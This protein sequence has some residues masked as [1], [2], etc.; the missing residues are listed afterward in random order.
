MPLTY[1]QL[2]EP[3]LKSMIPITRSTNYTFELVCSWLKIIDKGVPCGV[4][5]ELW[6]SN[7]RVSGSIH[8]ASN[9]KKLFIHGLTQNS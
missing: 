1:F 7:P 5:V 6:P 9:L 8:G 3:Q 2:P 4:G